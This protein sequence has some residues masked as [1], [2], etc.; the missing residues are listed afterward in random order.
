MSFESNVMNKSKPA[1]TRARSLA[2]ALIKACKTAQWP[3][4]ITRLNGVRPKLSYRSNL[5]DLAN[6]GLDHLFLSIT[7]CPMQ[8]RPEIL[9]FFIHIY[10][11]FGQQE[12][13]YFIE[14]RSPLLKWYQVRGDDALLYLLC[15]PVPED[16]AVKS[17]RL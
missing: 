1:L 4:R 5:S 3:K 15:H 2:P 13:Y 12:L 16:T 10:S 8:R 6:R 17:Y 11:T 14:Q 7:S 9:V